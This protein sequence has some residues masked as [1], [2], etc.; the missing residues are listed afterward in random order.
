MDLA[1]ELRDMGSINESESF[2][3][4]MFSSAKGGGDGVGKKRG[5]GSKVMVIVDSHGLSLA[6]STHAANHHK[7]RLV[8]LTFTWLKRGQ[9][10]YCRWSL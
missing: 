10:A 9:K 3:D 6:V 7:V 2:I 5:K 1:N 4:A 8:Q